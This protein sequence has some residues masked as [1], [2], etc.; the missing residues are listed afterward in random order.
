MKTS[1]IQGV[2]SAILAATAGISQFAP[3][4]VQNGYTDNEPVVTNAINTKGGAIGI[5]RIGAAERDN[6]A[7]GGRA[8]GRALFT[9][10]VWEDPHH[11]HTPSDHS[12]YQAIIAAVTA[13]HEFAW[14]SLET[15]DDEKGAV[16][17]E[18]N[19][20]ASVIY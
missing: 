2:V 9:L 13:R 12:L 5:R 10:V 7:S 19:F 11:T 14:E 15:G 1:E 20:T 4:I 6:A 3:C 18:I 16:V 8:L 17:A